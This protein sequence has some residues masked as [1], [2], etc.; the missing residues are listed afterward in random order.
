MLRHEK[1]IGDDFLEITILRSKGHFG[2][3][4]VGLQV[5]RMFH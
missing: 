4:S 1:F 2:T 3:V 5:S